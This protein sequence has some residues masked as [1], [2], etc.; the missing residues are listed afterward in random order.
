VGE[1]ACR[2][3]A[4]I[5]E[6]TEMDAQ[7]FAKHAAIGDVVEVYDLL[8]DLLKSMRQLAPECASR[9]E[10]ARTLIFSVRVELESGE[11]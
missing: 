11:A 1:R 5:E 9:V 3:R 8:D 10:T 2:T 6:G 7:Q 4:S